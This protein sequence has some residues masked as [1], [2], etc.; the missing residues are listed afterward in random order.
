MNVSQIRARLPQIALLLASFAVFL[1]ASLLLAYRYKY[2]NPPR[3]S[4]ALFPPALAVIDNMRML[5][6]GE[7]GYYRTISGYGIYFGMAIFFLAVGKYAFRLLMGTHRVFAEISFAETLSCYYLLGALSASLGWLLVGT[8]IGIDAKY[9]LIA[10]LLGLAI[11]IKEFQIIQ[12]VRA[13]ALQFTLSIFERVRTLGWLECT[14]GSFLIL[15]VALMS[16]TAVPPSTNTWSMVI[17]LPIAQTFVDAKRVFVYP[18]HY[19]SFLPL[20]LE[21]LVTWALSLGSE[22]A[23]ILL[24]WGFWVVAISWIYGMVSRETSRL[25][26]ICSVLLFAFTP[27]VKW[28]SIFIK[29][30]FPSAV[31]LIA[32]YGALASCLNCRDNRLRPRF[33]LLSGIFCGAA[34]GYK[35]T[36]LSPALITFSILLIYDAFGGKISRRQIGQAL[37]LRWVVGLVAVASPWFIRD[38]LAT[39]NP[40]YPLFNDLFGGHWIHY[41]HQRVHE[42]S[43]E[44][45][46]T[47]I[48]YF[49][50]M[51]VGGGLSQGPAPADFG[52]GLIFGLI[53]VPALLWSGLRQGTKL[54]FLSVIFGFVLSSAVWMFP[55]YQIAFLILITVFGFSSCFQKQKPEQRIQP[56]ATWI[57]VSSV[58]LH[59]WLNFLQ[60]NSFLMVRAS[61][62]Q[63]FSG[64]GAGHFRLEQGTREPEEVTVDDM[65]FIHHLINTRTSP[66]ESV[67]FVLTH[68]T[69]AFGLNRPAYYSGFEDKP[70]LQVLAEEA[71]SVDDL[72]EKLLQ[73]ADSSIRHIVINST[74]EK[75]EAWATLGTTL[76]REDHGKIMEFV[77]KHLV[78]RSI[79]PDGNLRWYTVRM[80]QPAGMVE[81]GEADAQS[82]PLMAVDQANQ[83]R[84]AGH[85][86]E[87]E[88][89]YLMVLKTK[90]LPHVH[91]ESLVGLGR[92]CL[93][94]GDL[95]R[96]RTALKIA[97]DMNPNSVTAQLY[98]A[99]SFAVS[100][101][102]ESV[103]NILTEIPNIDANAVNN[104]L[105]VGLM[106]RSNFSSGYKK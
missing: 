14:M 30:D 77:K 12:K 99:C 70:L 64:F 89:I 46:F 83:L 79:T 93:D 88:K 67:M 66:S 86:G 38:F 33:A 61:A 31:Y 21:M 5:F 74:F 47:F 4:I 26:G 6:R 52:P 49:K 2:F 58:V 91:S 97:A 68:H 102:W 16:I 48:S 27:L 7:G 1:T 76:S 90:S 15:A 92:M 98:L 84:D 41:W 78:L 39:G 3:Y 45:G 106:Q 51:L 36:A 11:A 65:L 63:L 34:A 29:N 85:L 42:T 32:H 13:N 60:S 10:M 23:A 87:A 80:G 40:V 43:F 54:T 69:F 19:H 25:I 105:Y 37:A 35:V 9:S 56:W 24:M 28:Y 50:S 82:F 59:F 44:G 94:Q 81:L 96:A 101:D 17:P 100:N 104:P 18:Y 73:Y 103:R 71:S 20:N 62:S 53:S 8:T 22:I 55:R 95:E 57:A 75:P 72:R